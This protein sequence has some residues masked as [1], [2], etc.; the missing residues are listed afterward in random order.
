MENEHETC[1][2]CGRIIAKLH[3]WSLEAFPLPITITPRYEDNVLSLCQR[4]FEH[5]EELAAEK[6]QERADDKQN[7][8]SEENA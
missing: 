1:E 8:L 2:L 7:E 4:C 3:K 6:L 5:W